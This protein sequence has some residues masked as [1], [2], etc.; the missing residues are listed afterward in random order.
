M[1]GQRGF[2]IIEMLVAMAVLTIVAGAAVGALMQAQYTTNGI[3]QMANVQENLRAGMHFMVQDFMQSG[4][5]IPPQGISVPSTAAGTSAINRPAI[6]GIFP[7]NPTVIPVVI[8]EYQQGALAATVNP[9]TNAVLL[10]GATD[11]ITVIYA[12]NTLS[13]SNGS[14]IVLNGL[15]VTQAAPAVPVCAGIIAASGL[16][17]TMAPACFTLPGTPKPVVAGDLIMFSNA[18]GTAIEFVTNVAGNVLTFAA[19]DPAGLNQTGLPNGTVAS[20]NAS[21]TPTVITRVWMVTYY[22]D[23]TTPSKPQ[24]V[25][26]INYPGYPAASPSYPPQQISDAIEDLNFTYDVIN[27]TDPVGTYPAGAGDAPQPIAPDNAFQIRAVNVMLAGRSEYPIGTG[28]SKTYYR[29]NLSTQVSIRSL[30]FVNQYNSSATAPQN[31]VP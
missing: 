25:R 7:N 3:A 17:V 12:D 10:G 5:G 18:N 8:P 20:I 24:L 16:T 14:G 1:K 11:T 28:S 6:G 9:Q 31:A 15:P 26:Q 30:A 23:T 4:E 2:S 21:A 27:S 13:S 29:N 22:I 19:G